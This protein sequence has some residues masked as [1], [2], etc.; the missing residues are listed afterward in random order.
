M[1]KKLLKD[2][3]GV[4]MR[5][6]DIVEITGGFFKRDNGF[7]FIERTPGD[8]NWNG[9]DYLL[10]RICR[11]GSISK[12]RDNIAFWPL[13]VMINDRFKKME[14]KE[15]NEKHAKIEV[16]QNFNKKHVIDYFLDENERFKQ[17]IIEHKKYAEVEQIPEEY[18]LNNINLIKK[19]I[20][21]NQM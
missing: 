13:S 18:V 12:A 16:I 8:I 19:S 7:Y 9:K 5:T 14:A 1:Q 3:N 6:G 17:R 10:K 4:E 15:H 2:V 11:N 20:S 21:E